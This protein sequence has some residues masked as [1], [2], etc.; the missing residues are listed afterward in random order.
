MKT[1]VLLAGLSGCTCT[2]STWRTC[3]SSVVCDGRTSSLKW[4]TCRTEPGALAE[5]RGWDDQWEDRGC[6]S[7]TECTDTGEI[8]ENP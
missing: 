5:I 4:A 7:R 8:C 3:R 2:E 6:S 1:V